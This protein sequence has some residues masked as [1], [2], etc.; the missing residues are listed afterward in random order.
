MNPDTQA[1]KAEIVVL[2]FEATGVIDGLPDE[3]WQIGMVRIR[4]GAVV[5]EERY[6]SWLRVGERPFSPY[7]PGR[8]AEL[9]A[10][11]EAAPTLTGLWPELRPWWTGAALAAHNAA[12]EQKFIRQA[13]P[14]HQP[15]PWLDTLKLARIAYP[16]LSSHKLEDLLE[17]LNLLP[18]VREACHGRR[19]HDALYDAIGCAALLVHLLHLEGWQHATIGALAAARPDAFYRRGPPGS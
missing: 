18:Q 15:G 17:S 19:A 11:L 13:F 2:D 4:Q 16:H 12:T 6:E 9:R 7:A 14:L 5:W 10:E 1:T 3:P 8:H